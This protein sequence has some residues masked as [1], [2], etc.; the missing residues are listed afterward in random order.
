MGSTLRSM[1][2]LLTVTPLVLAA[3]CCRGGPASSPPATIPTPPTVPIPERC[4]RRPPPKVSPVLDPA[5]IDKIPD[6]QL[7]GYL[8]DRID[9]LEQYIAQWWHACGVD[10]V[11]TP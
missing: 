6:A 5:T 4:I 2:L 3:A 10:P 8:F 1:K 7:V 9:D 11:V